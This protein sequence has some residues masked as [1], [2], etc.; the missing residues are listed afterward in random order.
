MKIM[1]MCWATLGFLVARWIFRRETVV[2]PVA[3][4][5]STGLL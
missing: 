4:L 3:R 5:R 1:Q 2:D